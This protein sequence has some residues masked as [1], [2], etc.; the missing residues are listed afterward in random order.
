MNNSFGHLR[1]YYGRM[2]EA[3]YLTGLLAG[4]LSPDPAIGYVADL[5]IYGSTAS[6]NAF[7]LGVRAVNPGASV[8]LE[9]SCVKDNRI[10]DYFSARH[11]SYVSGQDLLTPA[12]GSRQFGLYDIRGGQ[13]KNI[14]MPVW[15]WGKF[16]ERMIKSILNG[17]WKKGAEQSQNTSINYFWGLSS[18]M[19]DII[20]SSHVPAATSRLIDAVKCEIAAGQFHPFSGQMMDQRGMLHNQDDAAMPED[21]IGSMDWLLD[22]VHGDFPEFDEMTEEARQ[23]VQL[24]GIQKYQPL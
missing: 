7:A 9:W 1:T 20:C 22:N 8:Y 16:Y 13:I 3:K 21:Q 12:R 24:Q 18:G 15:H 2:Y 19:I 23:I 5:P 17:G 11:I 6:I 10:D 14:A 4:I